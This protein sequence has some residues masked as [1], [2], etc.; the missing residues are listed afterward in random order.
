MIIS[1]ASKK[2][3]AG[4]FSRHARFYD[5]KAEV[6]KELLQKLGKRVSMLI[7]EGEKWCDIGCGTGKLLDYT[8]PLPEKS[9]IICL[10]LAFGPL[11]IARGPGRNAPVVNG[12]VEYPPI[13]DSSLDG[14]ITSSMLQWITD[15]QKTLNTMISKLKTTH[16]IIF[17]VFTR[18]SFG[19]L[20]AV[21]NSQGLSV[22]TW[23]PSDEDLVRL[24]KN[25]GAE[26]GDLQ[27]FSSIRYFDSAFSALK[28]LN[29]VGGTAVSGPLLKRGQLADLCRQ[30]EA[31]FG[32][33][34][35]IPVTY[36][37]LLGYARRIK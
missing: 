3:I 5:S 8:G 1:Q 17:S 21:R 20:C 19:E 16:P 7:N 23:F 35:G 34:A 33:D 31:R 29:A 27:E 22:S 4:L 9:T 14:V 26:I 25:A 24:L 11:H 30:Y 13:R 36:K 32:T 28:S 15:P 10:D 6:Q 2:R 18:G 12:D 37:A